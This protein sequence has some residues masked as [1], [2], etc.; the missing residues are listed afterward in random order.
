MAP[1]PDLDNV[2][3]DPAYET[4]LELAACNFCT[5]K[6]RGIVGPPSGLRQEVSTK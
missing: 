1:T 4:T 6:E 2:V 5:L 3:G